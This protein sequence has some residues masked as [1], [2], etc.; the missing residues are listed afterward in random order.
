MGV[1]VNDTALADCPFNPVEGVDITKSCPVIPAGARV[2]DPISYNVTITNT[3]DTP[4]LNIVV[5]EDRDGTLS[6]AFPTELAPGGSATRTF[7]STITLAD[8][9]AGNVNNTASVTANALQVPVSD[10][11]LASA[12]STRSKASTSPSLP[13]CRRRPGRRAITY[14]VTITNTGDTTLTSIEVTDARTVPSTS[15]S[16]P[17][18]IRAHQ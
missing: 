18:S 15:R 7:T 5:T 9:A 2:G 10:T 16:R 3:G 11:A 6:S 1:A 17:R 8:A 14:S 13:V 4:L 12:R